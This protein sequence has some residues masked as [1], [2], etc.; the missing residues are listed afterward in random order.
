M[1]PEGVAV[2]GDGAPGALGGVA[3]RAPGEA[4]METAAEGG[5]APRAQEDRPG[6]EA[7]PLFRVFCVLMLAQV[8]LFAEAGAVP[9]LLVQLASSF[10][11]TFPQQGYLGGIVYF[12]IA[13]GA[14]ITSEFF[15]CLNPKYILSS[16]LLINMASVL[17]FASV[18]TGWTQTL[19]GTRFLIGFTQATFSVYIPVWVDR[20]APR[21]KATRWFSWLQ[22][23]VPFGIMLGYVLGWCAIG[24]QTSPN[25]GGQCL[26]GSVACWRLPFLFQIILTFPVCCAL[27]SLQR[28][29]LDVEAAS[30]M[31]SDVFV[32]STPCHLAVRNYS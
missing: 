5:V 31:R 18:P 25:N 4:A 21:E 6:K 1:D 8:V 19:I 3:P 11:L 9:A 17:V 29:Q 24:L 2:A 28:K 22:I 32:N 16:T 27:A 15:K 13:V 20:F 10:K 12:G 7:E 14:P 30:R 23:T 26:G